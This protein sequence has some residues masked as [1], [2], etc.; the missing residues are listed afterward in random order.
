V[1][2]SAITGTSTHSTIIRPT[3]RKTIR[4][5]VYI[6]EVPAYARYPSRCDHIKV[7]LRITSQE[8]ALSDMN[9][10]DHNSPQ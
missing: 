2:A 1:S 7:G 4:A 6:H 8:I 9:R 10:D 3:C 5:P